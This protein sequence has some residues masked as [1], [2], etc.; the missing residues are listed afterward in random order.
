MNQV[1]NKKLLIVLIIFIALLLGTNLVNYLIVSNAEEEPRT[2]IRYEQKTHELEE[3]TAI[4]F[5]ALQRITT[6]YFYPVEVE[7]LVEGA[8]RGMIDILDDPQVRFYDPG[9]LEEFLLDARG[10]YGGIGIRIIEAAEDIVVF[11]VFPDSPAERS[12]IAAGDRILEADEITIT[13]EG[14]ERAVELLRGPGDTTVEVIIR[15]PGSEEPLEIIVTRKEIQIATVSSERLEQDVGYIAISNFDSNTARVFLEH[16]NKLE[17]EGLEQGLILDLR[18][19]PGGLFDQAVTIARDIVPEGEIVRLIGR[20]G[21]VE[22]IFTSNAEKKTYPIVVLINE[23]SASAAELLAGAMQDRGAALLVGKTTFGK[24]SVQKLEEL[25]GENAI[26]LTVANYFTPSGHNIDKHGIAPDYEIE[27]PDI[28]HYYRYFHPGRLELN[29]YGPDVKMLQDML[30]QL[31]YEL[32]SSGYFDEATSLV[33]TEFQI[34]A[35]LPASGEFDDITWIELRKKLDSASRKQ[36]EQLNYGIDL[37][38]DS[39]PLNNTGGTN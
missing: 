31:G 37:I 8:V 36:D 29:D 19:N 10:S 1:D 17:E 32:E 15:R 9:E 16:L 11:D 22:D 6:N 7:D 27:M 30:I 4:F 18:N 28:L 34:E 38:L 24:A 12:G 39:V 14:I 2:I 3:E 33:L 35:D 23:D 21:E 5:E 13:G 26:M 20:D 25:P